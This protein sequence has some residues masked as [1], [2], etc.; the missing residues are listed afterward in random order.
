MG[1]NT[2]YSGGTDWQWPRF[3]TAQYRHSNAFGAM[4]GNRC[5]Y[6]KPPTAHSSRAGTVLADSAVWIVCP[7]LPTGKG[8][9]ISPPAPAVRQDLIGLL[10]GGRERPISGGP[11]T[12][13]SVYLYTRAQLKAVWQE[14]GQNDSSVGGAS[15][16]YD[17]YYLP[18][19]QNLTGLYLGRAPMPI[20]SPGEP[21][22]ESSSS[23]RS[24]NGIA[25]H[26]FRALRQGGKLRYTTDG[27]AV[28]ASSLVYNGRQIVIPTGSRLV[29]AA[30]YEP[31]LSP[32]R[33]LFVSIGSSTHHGGADD[34]D[35]DDNAVQMFPRATFRG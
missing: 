12:P 32:S 18:A 35:D 16:F 23:N 24:S 8:P 34:D 9:G 22:D 7:R 26:T 10:Y 31:K 14:H 20:L 29:R 13:D 19:A 21:E 33:E 28:S 11:D 1:E 2:P 25:L 5:A 3:A 30:S 27:S 6:P 17:Q 15:S 4:K